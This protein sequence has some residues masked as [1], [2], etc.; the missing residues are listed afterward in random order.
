MTPQPQPQPVGLTICHFARLS[1]GRIF[2][3]ERSTDCP[4]P[5]IHVIEINGRNAIPEIS[6]ALEIIGH[7][8]DVY[9]GLTDE[10]GESGLPL[11]FH[12]PTNS[13]RSMRLEFSPQQTRVRFSNIPKT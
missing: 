10:I 4:C 13:G 7:V 3:A 6:M 1:D 2:R 9:G 5:Q 12:F 8:M 11:S